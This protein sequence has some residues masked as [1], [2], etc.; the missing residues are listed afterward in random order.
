MYLSYFCLAAAM[1]SFLVMLVCKV[2]TSMVT[3]NEF[4]GAS[5]LFILLVKSLV[6]SVHDGISF[7][8]CQR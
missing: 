3:K 7:V 8:R 4:S 2:F 5:K 6:S 1:C